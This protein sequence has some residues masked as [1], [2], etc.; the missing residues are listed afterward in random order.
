MIEPIFKDEQLQ[1]AF[2][3]NGYVKIPLLNNDDIQG[4]TNLFYQYHNEL[5]ENS[6]GASSF[7][8]DK[9]TKMKIRDMLYPVFLPY[10]EKIFKEYTY[11]GSSFL[12]KTKGKNSDLAPHQDWTIVDESKFVAINIW[13]PLIDT[14]PQNGTLYVVPK[15]QAQ[16]KF[17]LR[18]PTIPFYFLNYLDTVIKCSEPI[19]AR[20]GEA[21]I[22]NQSLIHY[23]SP[24]IVDDI[25]IAITSGI[26][27]KNAPM[28]FHYFE[29]SSKVVEC[30]RMPED[31]LLD[32]DNFT[33]DIY[34]RPTKGELVKEFQ[35]VNSV[36]KKEFI[37]LFGP[38][39]FNFFQKYF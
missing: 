2:D 25:R 8:H 3:E 9:I 16:K 29:E 31:F 26:K 14:T 19:N 32:F 6:F 21:V 39:K 23:S 13:T 5:K 36:T 7:M 15:S 34:K 24:N 28:N 27:S 20:A 10:F 18:A 35:Y 22:L 17:S 37:N 30:Y 1:K 4:L 11:F 38:N 33:E 12:Y